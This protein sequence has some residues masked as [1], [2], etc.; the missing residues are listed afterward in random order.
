MCDVPSIATCAC[1][2]GFDAYGIE[3]AITHLNTDSSTAHHWVHVDPTVGHLIGNHLVYSNPPR[4]PHNYEKE[5]QDAQ[6]GLSRHADGR[7]ETSS[8]IQG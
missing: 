6:A 2:A 8:K 7:T 1:G 3:Q 5:N 4:V